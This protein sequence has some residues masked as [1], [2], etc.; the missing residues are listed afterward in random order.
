[1]KRRQLLTSGSL[2]LD[3]TESAVLSKSHGETL[4][5]EKV[6]ASIWWRTKAL[7][8]QVGAQAELS[9]LSYPG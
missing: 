2:W 8:R 4:G 6:L 7:E 9:R 1:M 3:K 5:W